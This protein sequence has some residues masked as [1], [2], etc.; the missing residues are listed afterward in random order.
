MDALINTVWEHLKGYAPDLLPLF[1]TMSQEAKFGRGLLQSDIR[2]LPKGA[3]L[4]EVGGGIMLLS[5]QL[6]SEG[7]DVVAVE[8]TGDGFSAFEKLRAIIMELAAVKPRM[9]TCGIEAFVSDEKFTYAFS[10]N[11]M[12]HVNDAELAISRVSAVLA[13]RAVYRFFCPNYLFPYEPHFNIPLIVNKRITE[14][15]FRDSIHQNKM[16]DAAGVWKSLNWIDVLK[17]KRWV[18]KDPTLSLEFNTGTLVWMLE[19]VVRDSEFAARRSRWMVQAIRFMV[20]L[21]LHQIAVILPALVQPI[22]DVRLEK[23]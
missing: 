7:Y 2:H 20:K 22:M 15:F 11:V 5:C 18:K 19:R 16:P 8:P 17:V 21:Q 10:I 6:A 23:R 13:P 14:G 3:K 12:E 9:V 1:E 4:L